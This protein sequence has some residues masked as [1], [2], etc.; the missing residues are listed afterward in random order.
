MGGREVGQFATENLGFVGGQTQTWAMAMPL[1]YS[2]KEGELPYLSLRLLIWEN[3]SS[4]YG[5]TVNQIAW[6]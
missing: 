5:T 4:P 3:S 2:V 1:A 6:Y